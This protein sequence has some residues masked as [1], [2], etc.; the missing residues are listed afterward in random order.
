MATYNGRDARVTVNASAT[1][2]IVAEIGNWKIDTSADEIDTTAFGDGWAKSDVGM[3]KWSGSMS[4]Y[5]DSTDTTGQGIV[6]TAFLAGTLISDIRFYVEYSETTSDTVIYY[7]PD[8]VTDANA[9]LR[10]T[11]F[12]VGQDKNGVATIDFSFS[13]SGPILRTSEVLS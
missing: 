13:G 4:G 5:F 12:N 10:V 8:T 9:G 7:H 11:S 3:L 1:E 2:A 6:E